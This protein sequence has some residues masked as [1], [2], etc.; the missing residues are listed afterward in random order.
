[1]LV[2]VGV[3]LNLAPLVIIYYL[4]MKGGPILKCDIYKSRAVF[5]YNGMQAWKVRQNECNRDCSENARPP[6]E[7]MF[8]SRNRLAWK[9]MCR[10]ERRFVDKC[11]DI[12]WR[13]N[14]LTKIFFW[15]NLLT[16]TKCSDKIC[17]RKE[18]LLVMENSWII[19]IHST[20]YLRQKCMSSSGSSYSPKINYV[21][22]MSDWRNLLTESVDKKEIAYLRNLLTTKICWRNL[23]T[24]D[25]SADDKNLLTKSA[26]K[27]RICW[28][29][30]NLA[31]SMDQHNSLKVCITPASHGL[32]RTFQTPPI[33]PGCLL[34]PDLPVRDW[35]HKW[36]ACRIWIQ[37]HMNQASM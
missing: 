32:A 11:K 10:R 19:W 29:W 24:K 21:L 16:K 3:P 23:L 22:E 18:N 17:L 36:N 12:R 27:N 15:R 7:K 4:V 5:V 33:T 13:K 1:M 28:R 25:K 2:T 31:G 6:E 8:P 30:K 37:L 20:R 9:W 14:L 34:W 26:D 35:C